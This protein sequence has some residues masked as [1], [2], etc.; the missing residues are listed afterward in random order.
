ME[1]I[2]DVRLVPL[3]QSRFLKPMRMEYSQG[4]RA[5]IWDLMRCHSSVAIVIFNTDS[6]KFIF[7]QQFRPAVYVSRAAS[8]TGE[9][10]FIWLHASF[11]ESFIAGTLLN[12]G[13]SIDTNSVP[14]KVGITLE[15]C[16][17]IIDKV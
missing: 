13:D 6:Q 2:A 11:I 8:L 16:A 1:D 7:V 9:D 12:P 5:K 17:G 10:D 15:L 4:G 14:G 3:T